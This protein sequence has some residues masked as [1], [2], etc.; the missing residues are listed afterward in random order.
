LFFFATTTSGE[1]LLVSDFV[2]RFLILMTSVGFK[3]GEHIYLLET[4]ISFRATS[5]CWS[6][7]G[8]LSCTFVNDNFL[9]VERE[10]VTPPPL[11]QQH[12]NPAPQHQHLF[13]PPPPQQ[14]YNPHHVQSLNQ[15][16]QEHDDMLRLRQQQ[17]QQQLQHQ[18]LDMARKSAHVPFTGRALSIEEVHSLVLL[19]RRSDLMLCVSATGEAAFGISRSDTRVSRTATSAIPSAAATCPDS[20]AAS[21]PCRSL[22]RL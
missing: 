22:C 6:M 12:S 14:Q 19:D 13:H 11:Y 8:L 2:L 3:R 21:T 20:S 7:P 5:E 9:P 16:Y 1:Y 15:T 4:D 10:P 18:Q 17:Q